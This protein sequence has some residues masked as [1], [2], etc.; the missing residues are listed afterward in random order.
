MIASMPQ[1][2]EADDIPRYPNGDPV[3]PSSQGDPITSTPAFEWERLTPRERE[4]VGANN[5]LRSN[6]DRVHGIGRRRKKGGSP[7]GSASG[8]G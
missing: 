2:D 7:G 3:G 4:F 8:N 5:V 6:G 1:P